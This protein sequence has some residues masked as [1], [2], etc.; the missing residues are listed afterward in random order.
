MQLIKE[1]AKVQV[2]SLDRKKEGEYNMYGLIYEI[3]KVGE[4]NDGDTIF[5]LNTSFFQD[6]VWTWVKASEV[7]FI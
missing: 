6:E 4:D 3:E 2:V 5:A 7:R 1:G